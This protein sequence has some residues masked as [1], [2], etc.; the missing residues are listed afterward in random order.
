MSWWKNAIHKYL[1]APIESYRS[2]TFEHYQ[3]TTLSI[4]VG[5]Y[6]PLTKAEL[7]QTHNYLVAQDFALI[8]ENQYK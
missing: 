8:L 3:T 6:K 5:F 1:K 4:N 7:V 2:M